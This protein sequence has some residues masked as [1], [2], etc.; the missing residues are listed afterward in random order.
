MNMEMN[1]VDNADVMEI[2]LVEPGRRPRRVRIPGDFDSLQEAVAGHI[3]CIYPFEDQIGIVCNEEGKLLGLPF[4]R[5]LRNGRGKIYD[6]LVGNFLVVGLSD[7]EFCSL[8]PEL[9]E[10]YEEFYH[11]PDRFRN[12]SGYVIVT[13]CEDSEVPDGPADQYVIEFLD[14][15]NNVK[16]FRCGAGSPEMALDLIIQRYGEGV[17]DAVIGVF[18]NGTQVPYRC[19]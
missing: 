15:R 17:R 14:E 8:T 11:T 10:K 2:L 16:E 6:I 5:A 19:P 3:E 9:F 1:S 7:E 12:L 13:P 18:E 4:N